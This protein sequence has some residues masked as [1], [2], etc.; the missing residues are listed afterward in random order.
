VPAQLPTTVPGQRWTEL[1]VPTL[2]D[3]TPTATVTV[4]LPARDN[5]A[6]LDLTLAALRNQ[7][8]P[9]DLLDVVVVD[10]ASSPPL[11]L[12]GSQQHVRMITRQEATSHGSG[13]ARHAGAQSSSAD[14]LLFL[15][16]DMLVDPRH[17]EA[18]ARWHHVC[19]HA[20]VLG[21][22]WFVDVAGL[23]PEA[24][25]TALADG[26]ELTD[27]FPAAAPPQ[28]HEWQE[29][30]IVEQDDLVLDTDDAFLTV[31]GATVSIRREMYQACG[32][33][34]TFGLRGIVDTEFGFRAYTKG[35]LIVP[36]AQARSWHQGRR[37]FS[38]QGA[39]I[40]RARVGLAANHLPLPLFRPHGVGR[41]WAV[42]LV[43]V[44]VD[45]S[46]E[47]DQ[48]L[49][50]GETED[51]LLTVDAVLASDVT[52]LS[53]TVLT[54]SRELPGWWLDY[55][56][57]DARVRV[58]GEQR[59][60]GFPSPVTVVVPPGLL[61]GRSGLSHALGLLD[62]V[63]RVVRTL[64]D[65]TGRSVEVWRTRTLERV[66]RVGFDSVSAELL[67]EAWVAPGALGV[68]SAHVRVTQQGMVTHW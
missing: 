20:L 65:S 2:G 66:L 9:D 6:Q 24:I 4:V 16:S 38:T 49:T 18:H 14:I 28:R 35:C 31:V 33:F 60:S 10:D 67:G 41:Q 56:A 8:Y 48:P 45:L 44:L 62:D 40:K 46:G 22:K 32:G 12:P 43:T 39:S 34:A 5:Q 68:T 37:S 47:G 23:T 36:D 25:D 1:T 13:A 54:G 11:R 29:A 30:H 21:R 7:T 19:D 53:V 17:V 3:W 63:V 59:L 61:L 64:P 55:I 15:D 52:D 57:H 27:V 50:D 42:P 26:L 58:V 51:L